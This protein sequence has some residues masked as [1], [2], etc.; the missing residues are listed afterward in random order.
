MALV[1]VTDQGTAHG[2]DQ[3]QGD[4]GLDPGLDAGLG[5]DPPRSGHGEDGTERE[6]GAP[7]RQTPGD[8]EDDADN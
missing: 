6:I 5:R 8:E 1:E 3:D 4:A 2:D 7:T